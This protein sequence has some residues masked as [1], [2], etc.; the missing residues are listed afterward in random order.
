[1]CMLFSILIYT[2]LSAIFMD[3]IKTWPISMLIIVFIVLADYLCRLYIKNLFGFFGTHLLIM[4]I[5]VILPFQL[6]DK[7]ILT[8]ISFSFLLLAFGF[9]KSEANE[10]S[11]VAID[12]PFGA[13]ILFLIAH[14]HG[15][16]MDK[17][18]MFS[19]LAFYS[20][21]AGILYFLLYYFREYLDKFLAYS[22]S[23]EN[24]SEEIK[25]TFTTNVSLLALFNAF[26]IFII[27]TINMFFS[28][29]AYNVVGKFLKW[30]LQKLFGLFPTGDDN[31]SLE[32]ETQ[33][34]MGTTGQPE[35]SISYESQSPSGDGLNIGNVI[36]EVAQV[37][38][39]IVLA[40]AILFGIYSFIKTY[41][42]RNKNSKDVIKEAKKEEI[43]KVKIETKIE[44]E[45]RSFFGNNNEKIRKIFLNRVN[46]STKENSRIIIRPS[47]TPAQID[48]VLVKE[49]AVN[50]SDMDKLTSLYEKARYSQ[51]EISKDEVESVKHI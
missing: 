42:H 6:A 9:W 25:R 20:Y 39:Y 31:A 24:F 1:M 17:S 16:I 11:K 22:L 23:S 18:D 21:I 37:I 38:L 13:I 2:Y 12:I 26:T 47:Y 46:K 14:V 34:P 41:L 30:I 15:S 45:K 40:F 51:Y 35:T 49:N 3:S 48:D 27:L 29:N 36:F 50:Q 33:P 8:I 43:K 28:G 5:T 10:R 4:A 32:P 7:I 44:K 19:A